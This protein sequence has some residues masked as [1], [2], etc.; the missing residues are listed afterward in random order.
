MGWYSCDRMSVF[1][2]CIGVM[3]SCVCAVYGY[4]TELCVCLSMLF[5]TDFVALTLRT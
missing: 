1:V 4:A 5:S 2:L 3:M